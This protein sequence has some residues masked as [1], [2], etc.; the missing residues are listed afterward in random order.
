MIF[1]A[2]LKPASVSAAFPSLGDDAHTKKSTRA[3]VFLS[4]QK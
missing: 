4:I 3:N 1:A 2:S